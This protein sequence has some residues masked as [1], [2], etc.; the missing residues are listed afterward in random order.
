M[1]LSIVISDLSLL[2]MAFSV[3]WM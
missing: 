1:H 2:L 3:H